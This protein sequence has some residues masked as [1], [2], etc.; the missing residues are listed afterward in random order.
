MRDG[1]ASFCR[2]VSATRGPHQVE[3]LSAFVE[4][5]PVITIQERRHVTRVEALQLRQGHLRWQGLESPQ[6]VSG[7]VDE[8]FIFSSQCGRGVQARFNVR[9]DLTQ[10][11][12]SA[13]IHFIP[14]LYLAGLAGECRRPAEVLVDGHA[15]GSISMTAYT[16]DGDCPK[17]D[18][19]RGPAA[20]LPDPRILPPED[21]NL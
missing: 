13:G 11:A 4:V 1:Q 17:E 19:P 7:G 20:G 5:F 9:V 16:L 21:T 3:F 12:S 8:H 2:R 18:A 14:A 10:E 6:R 15:F